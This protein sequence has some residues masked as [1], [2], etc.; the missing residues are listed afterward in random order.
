MSN[1]NS[2]MVVVCNHAD[3]PHVMPTMIMGASGVGIGEEVM[4]FFCPGGAQALV[5]PGQFRAIDE[6]DPLSPT[7][8]LKPSAASSLNALADANNLDVIV[9]IQSYKAESA[10]KLGNSPV[11][12][13]GYGLFTSQSFKKHAFAYA[14]I[15][16][17]IFRAHPIS[18]IGSGRTSSN[19]VPLNGFNWQANMKHLPSSE[20]DRLRPLI[21]KAADEAIETALK[22][23]NLVES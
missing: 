13:Q 17:A 19:L 10:F 4:L 12:L 6:L 14:N 16:I 9:V 11:V 21:E 7:H 5:D 22:T 1:Q 20:L 23:A 2:K 18:Y 8:R 3:A 15:S